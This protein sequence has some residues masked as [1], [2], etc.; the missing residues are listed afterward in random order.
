MYLGSGTNSIS[1]RKPNTERVAYLNSS[2]VPD[3]WTLIDRMSS[4]KHMLHVFGDS[5]INGG[6]GAFFV[7]GCLVWKYFVG[8][9]N[10]RI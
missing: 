7:M 4:N 8:D 10:G 2:L 6:F 9:D 3:L 1:L 5:V